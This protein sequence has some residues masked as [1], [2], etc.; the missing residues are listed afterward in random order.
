[1]PFTQI[2]NRRGSPFVNTVRAAVDKRG[3]VTIRIARDVHEAMGS[4]AEVFVSLGIAQSVG[5]IRVG[6]TKDGPRVH[7]PRTTFYALKTYGVEASPRLM[8][9]AETIGVDPSHRSTITLPHEITPSGLIIDVR[10]LMAK[11]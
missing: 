9:R 10:P 4:P 6:G 8:I 1:M 3:G 5:F 7:H 2:K 11:N